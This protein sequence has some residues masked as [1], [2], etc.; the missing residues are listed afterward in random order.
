MQGPKF[1]TI[2][3]GKS[4]RSAISGMMALRSQRWMRDL[5]DHSVLLGG[6]APND[7]YECDHEGEYL[8]LPHEIY[9]SPLGFDD[10]P[11]GALYKC[12]DL[13]TFSL[14]DLKSF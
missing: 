2:T 6:R 3:R 10:F 7:H 14:R 13:V 8:W 12:H 1:E 9:S 4:T 11:F 5:F